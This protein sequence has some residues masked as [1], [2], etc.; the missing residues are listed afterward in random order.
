AHGGRLGVD[1]AG[2]RFETVRRS[3]IGTH[4]RGREFR[5]G[6]PVDGTSAA[7]HVLA[8]R[9]AMVTAHSLA[10]LA[11]APTA[12]PLH[13]S[14][15]ATRALSL[16]GGGTVHAVTA[17][18]LLVPHGASL[19]DTWR[20]AM[21]T[22]RPAYAGTVDLDATS[23]LL[24]ARVDDSRRVEGSATLF[25]PSPVVGSRDRTLR[26]PGETGLPV[27]ADLD[28]PQ[29]TAARV[30]LPLRE[31]DPGALTAGRLTGPSVD[32][33]VGALGTSTAFDVTR[34]DPRFEGLMAYAH[35]DRLQRY[36]Q[37]LGFTG[38]RGVN[39]EPQ[40][41]LATRLE[42]FDQSL[43]YAGTDTIVLGTGGVDDGE[44]AEI[45]VHEYG[46][47][48][49]FAQV[50]G[51]VAS[52]ETGAMG[53]GFGDFLAGAFFASGTSRGFGDLC[54]GDWDATSYS[55]SAE[56]CLRRLDSAKAYPKD[57]TGSVH[58]NGELWSAF[59]WRLRGRLSGSPAERSADSLRLVVASHELLSARARFG[60]GVA[61]LRLAVRALGRPEWAALVDA[62]ARRTGFPLNP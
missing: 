19:V 40:D 22:T 20:V 35:L 38:A 52:G 50:P 32:V 25:D 58:Q 43:F 36:L 8:G 10:A 47:A 56:P 28:S 53:E 5:G 39:A 26:Q 4:V 12:T 59:L 13:R 37:S 62:E 17:Q 15:A 33:T 6:V 3:L 23:G 30:S 51:F 21:V 57:L 24:L 16:A 54:I 31:L 60:E 45:V 44:D 41:V 34:S 2:F 9:I 48:M 49:Q 14:V 18:R 42:G 1:P 7:V 27:D 55:R 11:G 61:A 29:L 46:H